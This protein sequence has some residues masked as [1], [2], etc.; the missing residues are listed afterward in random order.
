M[1]RF[2]VLQVDIPE[3]N[4]VLT[5]SGILENYF[6]ESSDIAKM[7]CNCCTHKTKC[8]ETGVCKPKP[9][10][11]QKVIM[12][13]PDILV[14][15]VNRFKS[16]SNTKIKTTVWPND[17]LRLPSGD[18]YALCGIGHH[19]GEHFTGGHYVASVSSDTEWVRCNDTTISNSTESDSKSLECNIC[20]YSKVFNSTTPFN[21]TDEW[22]NLKGRHAPGGL[23]CNIMWPY[24]FL[25]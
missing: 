12:K 5:L 21:P 3:T 10:V 17:N 15:Q 24:P 1:D 7:R 8:P 4:S 11:S 22:Q 6:S 2:Q 25:D 9:F 16:G 20:I 13:S 18:E 23:R 19:I 14:V